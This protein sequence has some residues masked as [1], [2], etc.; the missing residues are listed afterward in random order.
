MCY[1]SV[2]NSL[3]D[4]QSLYGVIP[5]LIGVGNA[6]EGVLAKMVK[7]RNEDN[8]DGDDA[9]NS[10][11]NVA[12]GERS[13]H[14]LLVIDRE[15]D[16]VTPLLTPLTYEGLIDE[17]IGVQNGY[18]KVDPSLVEVEDDTKPKPA[19]TQTSNETKKKDV[20]IPLNSSDSLFHVVRNHN[21]EKLG[22]FLQDSAKAIRESYATF[23]ANKD[24]S[25]TEIHSFVKQ[26]PGL[27]QNYKSL[28]LH[29]NLA[30]LIKKRTDSA[31]FRKRWTIEREMLEGE[32]CYEYL[33]ELIYQGEPLLSTMKLLCLQSLTAGGIKSSKYDQ[34]KKDIIQSYGFTSLQLLTNLENIG[35]I[36]RREMSWTES[37]N[38]WNA[39]RK[40]LSLI[41]EDV[42][43]QDPDDIS[44]VSSGYAPLSVRL[45]QSVVNAMPGT[46]SDA[47]KGIARV[48]ELSQEINDNASYEEA[49][50]RGAGSNAR[51]VGLDKEGKKPVM[52]V[53]YVGGITLMEMAAL[54]YLSN[55]PSFPFAIVMGTTKIVNG[56]QLL[57]TLA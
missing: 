3:L 28:N 23:R 32:N 17:V 8:V 35:A 7:L 2:A 55:I 18:I 33:E 12:D 54:R 45:I 43:V 6:A 48:V 13:I 38:S 52:L 26:I 41:Q 57:Q 42:D 25:I 46:R 15:A 20:T 5:N 16:F 1:T 47:L 49:I 30:E 50:K 51:E 11:N 21:I 31:K 44:Y 4:F 37:G 27:N 40:N 56:E 22:R 19:A 10:T 24:L 53:Y 14:T 34:L 36:K 29:I 9:S 39:L